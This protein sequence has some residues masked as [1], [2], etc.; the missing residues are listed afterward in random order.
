MLAIS[1]GEL[2]AF[3]EDVSDETSALYREDAAWEE[4][5]PAMVDSSVDSE[6]RVRQFI[7]GL[8][9]YDPAVHRVPALAIAPSRS[10][11]V[12][13][14]PDAPDLDWDPRS[15]GGGEVIE[16]FQHREH[17]L[18]A[19]ITRHRLHPR[20]LRQGILDSYEYFLHIA[21]WVD[22]PGVLFIST[23]LTSAVRLPSCS[24]RWA[25]F[26]SMRSI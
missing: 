10:T 23:E 18:L 4:L 21:T 15:I 2:V 1:R 9:T 3:S 13:R 17:R 26:P 14:L 8:T 7:K 25:F 20:F 22:A 12:Y 19:F 16:R 11:H 5:L 24:R 6:R